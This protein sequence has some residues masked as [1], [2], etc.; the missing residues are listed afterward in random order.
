M[1]RTTL[2]AEATAHKILDAALELFRERGFDAATMREIAVKAEVATGA[3][4]YYFPS[5]DALVLAFYQRSC[6]EMQPLIESALH[7][8]RGLEAR[9]RQLIRVKFDYFATNRAVLRAL[10]R[11]GADPAH[12]I[13][14]FN[15]ATRAIRAVDIEWFHKI[16]EDC[17]F[18]VPR[19]LAPH[20][21][22]V[23]WLF[24]MG[25]IFFWVTDDSPEQARARNLLDRASK[26]VA[27][28]I[29]LSALPLMRPVRKVALE[30]IEIVKRDGK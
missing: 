8:V 26:A 28:L 19:D 13:S 29:R 14:P 25:V 5:K 21:P 23:L 10:L 16:L 22:D 15:P 6:A 27:V 20:L 1:T 2:K 18:S 17:G 30:L 9:L 3:A 4:Y 11:N 7:G 12:P 24:Q